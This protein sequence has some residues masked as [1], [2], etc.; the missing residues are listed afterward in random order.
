[1]IAAIEGMPAGTI[2]LRGSGRL[3]REDYRDVLEPALSKG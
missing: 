2:G 1:M 3:T